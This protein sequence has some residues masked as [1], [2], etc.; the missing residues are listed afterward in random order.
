MDFV[1]PSLERFLNKTK[2][3]VVSLG[4]QQSEKNELM[5]FNQSWLWVIV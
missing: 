5:A 2:Q 4:V 3:N 1:K